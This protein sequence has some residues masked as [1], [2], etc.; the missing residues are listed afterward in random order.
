MSHPQESLDLS[1]DSVVPSAIWFNKNLEPSA[2]KLYAMIRMLTKK[3]GYCFASNEYLAALIEMDISSIKRLMKPLIAEGYIEIEYEKTGIQTKRYIYLSDKFKKSLRRLKNEPTG[4]QNS[5]D[6]G[7]KISPININSIN[8]DSIKEREEAA[9]PPPKNFQTYKKLKLNSSKLET[10]LAEVG[11]QKVKEMMDR[12]DEYADINPKRFKEYGCHVT[13]MRKWIR[14][15]KK[16]P[17]KAQDAIKQI[18][19]YVS[20]HSK[21]ELIEK[22]LDSKKI[23]IG[24]DYIDFKEIRDG[25][26]IKFSDSK[27]KMLIDHNLYKMEGK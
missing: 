5:A 15:E 10:L 4:A 1:F 21:L 25:G 11:E 18:Q 7:S 13:V 9:P 6:G 26:Y 16:H 19:E 3:H 12:L 23:E 22:A 24:K 8:I 14:E 17:E 2:I 27:A 20:T